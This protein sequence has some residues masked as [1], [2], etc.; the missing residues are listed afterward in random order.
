MEN[1]TVTPDINLQPERHHHHHR[2]SAWF[3]LILIIVGL[4]F[5]VQ[6]LHLANFTFN[7]SLSRS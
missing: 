4:V 3:P 2:G 7:W 6:N 1:N 5:L